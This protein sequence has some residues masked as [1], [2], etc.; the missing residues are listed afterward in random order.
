MNKA[1]STEMWWSVSVKGSTRANMSGQT[2]YYL[3]SV[4][5]LKI[6]ENDDLIL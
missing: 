5:A 3:V 6:D 4:V 1:R 2:I